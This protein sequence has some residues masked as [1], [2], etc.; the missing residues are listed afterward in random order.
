MANY[1]KLDKLAS[2]IEKQNQQPDPTPSPAAEPPA[3]P[4]AEPT[5]AEPTPSPAAEPPKDTTPEPYK[6]PNPNPAAPPAPAKPDDQ[7]A[8][9]EYSFKRQLDK[10]QK[11]YEKEIADLKAQLSSQG[12]TLDMF[13]DKIPK[14]QTK[15]RADFP[16]GAG[17]DDAYID[18]LVGLR[19]DKFKAEQ[20]AA[21]DKERE[22]K[23]KADDQRAAEEA[24]VRQ[25]QSHVLTSF[26]NDR[27]KAET[28]LR[29]MQYLSNNGLGTI[30]DNAPVVSDYLMHNVKGPRVFQRVISDRKLFDYVFRDNG[31]SQ[32]DMYYA[33]RRVEEMM[34]N[35]KP[36]APAP[37]GNPAPSPTPA[38]APAGM[39]NIGK[40]GSQG[41]KGSAP[42]IFSD[43]KAMKEFLRR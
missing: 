23:Q 19:I 15:T 32:N 41:G 9:A 25:W 34:E 6:E 13:K 29:N 30:L 14:E 16:E 3:E 43:P 35:E 39:P 7:L 17:G 2:D 22:E 31:R 4:P 21:L 8:R 40:P 27:E 18:Y 24:E 11:K 37:A 1:S 33:I 12:K 28:F 38:P 36:G 5:P 20:Q 10:Q 42:D 26:E